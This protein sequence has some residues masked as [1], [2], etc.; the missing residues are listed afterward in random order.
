MPHFFQFK[1]EKKLMEEIN[2]HLIK[3]FPL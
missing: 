3:N 2:L 1:I